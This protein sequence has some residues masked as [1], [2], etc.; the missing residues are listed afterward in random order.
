M[1]QSSLPLRS[2]CQHRLG[3][4]RSVAMREFAF[5]RPERAE[6]AMPL[7]R[8]PAYRK[9][10]ERASYAFAIGSI[11]AALDVA[12]GTVRDVRLSFGALAPMPWRARLAEEA[13]R[14]QTASRA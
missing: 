4:Y 13:L 9:V 3:H 7:A 2:L 10:R 14:G 1:E 6:D 8:R 5:T 11:A 12:G